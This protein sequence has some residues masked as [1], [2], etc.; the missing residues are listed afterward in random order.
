[1][2]ETRY[3]TLGIHLAGPPSPFARKGLAAAADVLNPSAEKINRLPFTHLD[4]AAV[5]RRA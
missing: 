1:M 4:Y 5:A 2:T 3:A